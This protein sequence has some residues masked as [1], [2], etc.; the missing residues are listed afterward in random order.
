MLIPSVFPSHQSHQQLGTRLAEWVAH[1]LLYNHHLVNL[2]P[3]LL[4]IPVAL[5]AHI[6]QEHPLTMVLLQESQALQEVQELTM[7]QQLVQTM[8][9]A[10]E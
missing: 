2:K 7:G 6:T 5:V 3:M 4:I 1:L 8:D 10:Q 9:Q